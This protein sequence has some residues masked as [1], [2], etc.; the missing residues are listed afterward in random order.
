MG[1][2]LGDG[3]WCGLDWIGFYLELVLEL[4]PLADDAVGLAQSGGVGGVQRRVV[5]IMSGLASEEH[6]RLVLARYRSGQV[7]ARQANRR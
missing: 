6:H 4:A 3:L 1:V 5:M 7:T 2:V